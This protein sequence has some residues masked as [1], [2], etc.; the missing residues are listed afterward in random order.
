M[1][2]TK[3]TKLGYIFEMAMVGIDKVTRHETTYE[4]AMYKALHEL[5]R[6][7]KTR[8]GEYVPAPAVAD[9]TIPRLIRLAL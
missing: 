7:Q 2:V 8:A 9:L 6:L 5:E 4:R 3:D 1:T